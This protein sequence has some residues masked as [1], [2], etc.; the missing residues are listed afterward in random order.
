[1]L[2]NDLVGCVAVF[3]PRIERASELGPVDRQ[4]ILIGARRQQRS[5][6]GQSHPLRI[7]ILCGQG[8][9]GDIGNAP[10]QE[11]EQSNDGENLWQDAKTA[12]EMHFWLRARCFAAASHSRLPLWC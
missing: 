1:M 12:Q 4:H 5:L 11:S 8:V 3:I 2:V 9:D 6:R 10:H 7:V